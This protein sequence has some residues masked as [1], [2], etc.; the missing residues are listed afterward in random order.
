VVNIKCYYFQVLQS[1]KEQLKWS[2][3]KWYL[4]LDHDC[5][6][7]PFLLEFWMPVKISIT[8]IITAHYSAMWWMLDVVRQFCRGL[9]MF[10]ISTRSSKFRCQLCKSKS[11]QIIKLHRMCLWN[12][13][14]FVLLSLQP[15]SS[16]NEMCSGRYI[17]WIGNVI[18]IEF[19][20]VRNTDGFLL[21]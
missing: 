19:Y 17:M 15:A 6:H 8:H 13:V 11:V 3:L 20:L 5:Q 12:N 4:S 16:S 2:L 9:I 14:K 7:F 10:H 1:A 18:K 21:A